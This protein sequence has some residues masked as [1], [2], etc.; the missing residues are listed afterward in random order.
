MEIFGTGKTTRICADSKG[1]ATATDRVIFLSDIN[2]FEKFANNDE[3]V[4]LDVD[5]VE[6]STKYFIG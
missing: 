1:K 2:P 4:R 6:E 5:F 3:V